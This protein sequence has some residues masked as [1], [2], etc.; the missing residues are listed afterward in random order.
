MFFLEE[1]S[2]SEPRA[3]GLSDCAC[4]LLVKP[5]S[6]GFCCHQSQVWVGLGMSVARLRAL[7]QAEGGD[8]A[9]LG[10]AP[11]MYPCYTSITHVVGVFIK[12]NEVGWKVLLAQSFSDVQSGN[13]GGGPDGDCGHPLPAVQDPSI[14]SVLPGLFGN[15][16]GTVYFVFCLVH[17]DSLLLIN[18]F[19]ILFL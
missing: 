8:G 17:Y 14:R 7:E 19:L 13:S 2:R 11:V 18:S 4:P 10:L 15:L 16:M 1:N 5:P 12:A 6:G 3:W 9:A